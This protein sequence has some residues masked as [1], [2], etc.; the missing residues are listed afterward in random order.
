MESN[1]III[2]NVSDFI[3]NKDRVVI[4]LPGG[5]SI[6]HFL[7]KLKEEKIEWSKVHFFMADE[8]LVPL[9]D[10]ESNFKLLSEIFF[11]DL[12]SSGKLS[13][14]NLHPYR[15]EKGIKAY[16]AD[17]KSLGG[18]FNL[19]VLGV[20]EDGHVAGLFP[21][22]TVKDNSECFIEF[23]DS[24]KPPKDRMSSSRKLL[25]KSDLA[26]LLF[27]GEAK[28]AAYENYLDEKISWKTCPAKILKNNSLIYSDLS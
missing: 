4:A 6:V 2:K 8:R 20:G 23:H 16:E 12:I 24:P 21:D 9:N 28:R 3:K 10:K 1:D 19:V 18:K 7:K 5:R 27:L 11:S 15:I 14:F 25:V 13:P 17:L 22:Y 26:V